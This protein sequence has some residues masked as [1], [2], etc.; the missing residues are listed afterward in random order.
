MSERVPAGTSTAMDGAAPEIR[1]IQVLRSTGEHLR[2]LA[3]HGE[4]EHARVLF[5]SFAPQERARHADA[6]VLRQVALG[7][8]ARLK[9]L[10]RGAEVEAVR[11]RD[12]LE[13][14]VQL[15]VADCSSRGVFPRELF[16]T[17]L[18]WSLELVHVS[19][20]TEAQEACDLALSIGAG[21]F[22]EI[23]PWIQIRKAKIQMLLGHV[24]A[25]YATL[26]A[27]ER[28]RD[29][30]ADRQAVATMLGLLGHVSLQT[31]RAPIFKRLVVE[32]LRAFH[33]NPGERWTAVELMLRGY[34]TP[35]G[36]LSSRDVTLGDK[37][38]WL[39]CW[40][41]LHAARRV[42]WRRGARTLERIASG[43]AYLRQY[44][45]RG[46][47]AVDS[48]KARLVIEA[49][50]VTRAMGGIGDFLMMTPGLHALRALRPNRPLM[51]AVPR[52]FFPLFDGNTDVQLL[53]MGE[54]LDP[55]A[56]REWFNLTD[57][58][59]ARI[60][61]RT[62]P[63]V[64]ANRIELFA[65]GLGINGAR[66]KA[67]DRRPRYAVSEEERIWRDEFFARNGLGGTRVIGVQARTDEAYRDL[68]H[69]RQIVESLTH[70]AAVIVFGRLWPD[71]TGHPRVRQISG[72]DLRKS[73]A[74]ASGCD[75]IVTPDS[76]FFHLGG[77]LDLPC[78]GLFGPTDGRIR[79]VDYPRA[80]VLDARR[81]LRCVPC[82]RNEI[83]PCGLTGLRPSA[84]LGEI[85]PGEVVNA[86]E[87]V[88]GGASRAAMR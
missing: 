32:R 63:R 80:H 4:A 73:F 22:P 66:L 64:K 48:G 55:S 51:L 69:M 42:P 21:D 52:R 79:G 56:Y 13:S 65:R 81:K 33:T 7:S 45:V 72:L 50:L 75:A 27:S 39:T 59:A 43:A 54:D 36:L 38:L 5:E 47:S 37:L 85:D 18:D 77:A 15:F 71:G 25:A 86:V 29:R 16:M 26:S 44:G 60:E 46:G 17:L 11:E 6:E 83:T 9:S 57:C 40:S 84:C 1:R 78:V 8:L 67:M 82:W 2:H 30:I 61:S 24:E 74:L 49:T 14:I 31:R 87:A 53:D 19:R 58:P 23:G 28:R 20:L 88:I 35:L 62:A 68:P 76:A 3:F 10:P 41:S 12:F 70:N 34:R